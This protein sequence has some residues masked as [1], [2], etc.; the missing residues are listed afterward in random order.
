MNKRTLEKLTHNANYN[1]ELF[2]LAR[3]VVQNC[4]QLNSKAEGLPPDLKA[5]IKDKQQQ[6]E[7]AIKNAINAFGKFVSISKAPLATVADHG[8][9]IFEAITDNIETS[10]QRYKDARKNNKIKEEKSKDGK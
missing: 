9:N 8:L 7:S 1:Q 10:V 2:A 5:S 6:L 4:Q 3:G